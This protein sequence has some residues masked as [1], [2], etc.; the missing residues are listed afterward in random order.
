MIDGSVIQKRI[1][2]SASTCLIINISWAFVA[3]V[4]SSLWIIEEA[5]KTAD[6]WCDSSK[7]K[8][9][10]L[11]SVVDLASD[12]SD[13]I[14]YEDREREW[15]SGERRHEKVRRL[16][17]SDTYL[18]NWNGLFPSEMKQINKLTHRL[19]TS[20]RDIVWA[21][22]EI[23]RLIP[24]LCEQDGIYTWTRQ[25]H[26]PVLLNQGFPSFFC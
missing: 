17:P 5:D 20:W 18:F 1:P 4:A 2:A 26:F 3:N 21:E 9:A 22:P 6:Y 15:E 8:S 12:D 13:F 24:Y 25:V 10:S 14:V 23:W 7:R 16:Y 19:D 11:C